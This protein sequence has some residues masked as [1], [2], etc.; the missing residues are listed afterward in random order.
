[1]G[2]LLAVLAVIGKV[3]LVIL[4]I[5]LVLIALILFVPV[6]Y[7]AAGKKSGKDISGN[8]RI[9]WLLGFLAFEV[10]LKKR[11]GAEDASGEA[12]AADDDGVKTN[13]RILGISP[14]ERKK[15]REEDRKKKKKEKKKEKIEE[16]REKDP[17]QYAR[18]REEARAR[19][20]ARLAAEKAEKERREREEAEAKE[21][22]KKAVEKQKLLRRMQLKMYYSMGR[23]YRLA[24]ALWSTVTAVFS[25]CM[26]I[27]LF[28]AGLPSAAAEKIGSFFEKLA[29]ILENI[30]KWAAFLTSP[31]F[32]Q[33]IGLLAG[34]IKKLLG[35]ISPRQLAGEVAFGLDDPG[36]TGE[37]LAAVSA[38][39]PKYGGKVKI[40]PDFS[41][42]TS[43]AFDLAGSGRIYL[44]YLVYLLLGLVF[45]RDVRYVWH[46][47]KNEKNKEEAA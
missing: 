47:I 42:K 44:F 28:L 31:P 12:G 7:Q 19:R 38:F 11:L 20:E 30:N 21:A 25:L 39:Y 41:G 1:M 45:S 36:T 17:D 22:E 24:H 35:H 5:V 34:D 43:F 14:G 9:T 27:L 40:N 6:R 46:F 2:I 37:V 33:T 23:M 29:E 10:S 32:T 8:A 16:I 3:L 13:F 26:N 18:L 15:K 4:L